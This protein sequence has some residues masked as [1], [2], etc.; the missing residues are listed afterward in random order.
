MMF[1]SME[2]HSIRPYDMT[3]RTAATHVT[4]KR[5]VNAAFELFAAEHYEDVTLRR[6]AVAAGVALQTVV[7][8]FESKE[9]VF[10]AVVERF[11]AEISGRR[12]NVAPGDVRGA[13]AALVDDYEV[14]GDPTIKTLAIEDRVAAVRP[15]M[16]RGRAN[17]RAWVQRV[18]P[19]ALDGLGRRER[20]RRLA[21][22][23]AATDVFT[24]RLLRRDQ[25]LS[26]AE[27]V[28]AMAEMVQALH[29]DSKEKP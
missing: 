4:R 27:T 26:R 22:L 2:Q 20:R 7:N 11:S 13:V 1:H 17:H 12:D 24:W 28:L 16:A 23:V 9:S 15:A 29:P 14:T 19:A 6:I 3:T 5:I 10:A 25:R 21:Q 18:F 8:H